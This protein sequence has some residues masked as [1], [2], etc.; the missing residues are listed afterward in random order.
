MTLLVID[1]ATL[2]S[3]GY[4]SAAGRRAAA[5]SSPAQRSGGPL[6]AR[7]DAQQDALAR[8]PARRLDEPVGPALSA[9]YRWAA[10][11]P[12]FEY[13]DERELDIDVSSTTR[14]TA[15]SVYVAIAERLFAATFSVS[16]A[17]VPAVVDSHRYD[18]D[19]I[20]VHRSRASSLWAYRISR[21]TGRCRTDWRSSDRSGV[22]RRDDLA[23]LQQLPHRG[24]D[25][26]W[27]ID[28]A[29]PKLSPRSLPE[30]LTIFR[31]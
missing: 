31:W 9:E 4:R 7:T 13:V 29:P 11:L 10:E 17:I 5:R 20:R 2:A 8:T 6:A 12:D 1:F 27:N 26:A 3:L 21:A 24:A 23:L 30:L 16:P 19:D 18:P 15:R 28:A 14:R 22:R 25:R